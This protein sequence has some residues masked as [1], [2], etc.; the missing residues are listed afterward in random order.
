M[1]IMMDWLCHY[2]IVMEF[3]DLLLWIMMDTIFIYIYMIYAM[4]IVDLLCN[5][6]VMSWMFIMLM[7][8]LMIKWYMHMVMVIYA[9]VYGNFMDGMNYV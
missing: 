4:D 6:Y 2:G 7:Y 3:Y 5:Y 8:M 9:Y 1:D